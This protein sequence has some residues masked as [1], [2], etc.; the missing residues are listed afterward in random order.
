MGT[1][2]TAKSCRVDLEHLESGRMQG[3][4]KELP[5]SGDDK[6]EEERKKGRGDV[7]QWA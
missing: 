7:G 1:R 3:S 4:K 2:W 5:V 6:D